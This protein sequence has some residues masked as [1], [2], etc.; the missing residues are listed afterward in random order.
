MICSGQI[1]WLV[2]FRIYG[3]PWGVE[4]SWANHW[5]NH[6][7][8]LP[9]WSSFWTGA[10]R[11]VTAN[12][13]CFLCFLIHLSRDW[14]RLNAW[15][16]KSRTQTGSPIIMPKTA[17]HGGGRDQTLYL[18]ID[19]WIWLENLWSWFHHLETL[20][21]L[22]WSSLQL[23]K[24]DKKGIVGKDRKEPGAWVPAEVGRA[25]CQWLNW[26][27][28]FRHSTFFAASSAAFREGRKYWVWTQRI[29]NYAKAR[30]KSWSMINGWY[31]V[32]INQHLDHLLTA[33]CLA[34]C[35]M[36][37]HFALT[38]LHRWS[39]ELLRLHRGWCWHCC[40][41]G[42]QG[43]HV[44][45]SRSLAAATCSSDGW[46]AHWWAHGWRFHG[47]EV[48]LFLSPCGRVDV[49]G[50]HIL[51]ALLTPALGLRGVE[52]GPQNQLCQI[53]EYDGI[54][55]RSLPKWPLPS[56]KTLTEM[57]ISS[58]QDRSRKCSL[59]PGALLPELF[60]S[61]VE[62]PRP[63][64]RH[65]MVWMVSVSKHGHQIRS[66]PRWW[67]QAILTWNYQINQLD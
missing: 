38:V 11:L 22:H 4:S 3:G 28:R 1:W 10:P 53:R 42:C 62:T 55:K 37:R 41:G 24:K 27:K 54:K 17:Q 57:G 58:P 36:Y 12:L 31:V 67:L 47:R 49:G 29:P 44:Q 18:D 43:V 51:H 30:L 15:G 25:C 13:L 61:G 8:H 14:L 60:G 52:A 45:R 63:V 65:L 33:M 48:Q 23:L 2:S 9:I 34:C 20:H 39:H 21:Y 7:E 35:G 50:V 19:I 26:S 59:V 56:T 66:W 16:S 40:P 32:E 5:L 6:L 64:T 46:W